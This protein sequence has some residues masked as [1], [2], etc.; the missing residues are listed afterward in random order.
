MRG[1]SYHALDYDYWPQTCAH[2]LHSLGLKMAEVNS[3]GR[4]QYILCPDFYG[5][6]TFTKPVVHHQSCSSTPD[7]TDQRTKVN[8]GRKLDVSNDDLT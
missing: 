5:H 4:G 2:C 7:T 1:D 3:S 6:Y 8:G